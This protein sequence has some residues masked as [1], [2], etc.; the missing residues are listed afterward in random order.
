[1][2]IISPQGNKTGF[3]LNLTDHEIST[4]Y[5]N[6][7]LKNKDVY[8]FTTLICCIYPAL[9]FLLINVKLPTI[10]GILTFMSR[11]YFMVRFVKH[12]IK[13]HNFGVRNTQITDRH[14]AAREVT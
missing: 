2:H 10:V 9:I 6:K 13:F 11:I 8:W 5:K 7:M 4:I 1:M 14:M 12:E 3:M